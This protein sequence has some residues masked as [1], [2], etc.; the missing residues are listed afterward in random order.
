[1]AKNLLSINDLTKKDI[2][3]LIAFSNNFID[4]DA[5]YHIDNDIYHDDGDHL[6]YDH[7]H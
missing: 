2:L 6:Y 1:M 5:L 3:D 7:Y 4:E